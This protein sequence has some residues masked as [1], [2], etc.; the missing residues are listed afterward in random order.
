METAN[1]EIHRPEPA[2]NIEENEQRVVR[3]EHR[4]VAREGASGLIDSTGPFWIMIKRSAFVLCVLGS[5]GRVV[6]SKQCDTASLLTE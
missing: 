4:R 3:L 2:H 1:A 6:S 5:H